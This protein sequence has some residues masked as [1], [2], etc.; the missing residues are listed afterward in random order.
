M[1]FAGFS[2][3]PVMLLKMRKLVYC[4]F[5][6]CPRCEIDMHRDPILRTFDGQ[7][8][9]FKGLPGHMYSLITVPEI[10]QVNIRLFPPSDYNC[11]PLCY[12]SY[13]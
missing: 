4:V 9:E 6:T 13:I 8:F 5:C 7:D 11:N 3:G 1:K 12:N 10:F 2:L